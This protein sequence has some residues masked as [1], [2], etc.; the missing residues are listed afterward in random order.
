MIIGVA[1]PYFA[2]T[3]EQR[4]RNLDAMNEAAAKLPEGL[5]AFRQ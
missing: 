1:E 4:K 3:A 2:L 5:D